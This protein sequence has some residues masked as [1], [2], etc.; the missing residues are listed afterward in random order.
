MDLKD[1]GKELQQV[2]C[3]D[4]SLNSPQS[5]QA[6]VEEYVNENRQSAPIDVNVD[7]HNGEVV[8]DSPNNITEEEEVDPPYTIAAGRARTTIRKPAR[9]TDCVTFAFP[10]VNSE[11]PL[12]FCE[13]SES[14]NNGE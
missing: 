9:Y 1:H 8:V 5:V 2:E 12:N 10:I 4:L 3:G 6:R 11:T 14:S 7:V 13:A